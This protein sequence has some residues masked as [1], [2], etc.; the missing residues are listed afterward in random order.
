[1]HLPLA[2]LLFHSFIFHHQDIHV[3]MRSFLDFLVALPAVL[4]AP[5]L[6]ETRQEDSIAGSWIV[7]LK[8]NSV[9]TDVLGEATQALGQKITHTYDFG[10]FQ[11]F[12][13]DG[14]ADA[15][16]LLT[17]VASIA[18][19]EP[20]KRM[21]IDVLTSQANPPWGLGRISHRENIASPYIYDDSAGAGTFAYIVDTVSNTSPLH[22]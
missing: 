21:S 19:I 15:L 3:S 20:N 11:G 4:A 22:W 9:L 1:M 6:L 12:S 7:R 14:V 16:A 2:A 5:L 18:S 10:S 17:N 8:E 13:I